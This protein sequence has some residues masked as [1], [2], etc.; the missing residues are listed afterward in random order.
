[1]SS[2]KS[3][4]SAKTLTIGISQS[5]ETKDTIDAIMEAKKHG[6]N[7]SSMCNV[8]GSTLARF[9]GNGAYL[10]AGPEYAVAS[11][12]VFSNMVATGLLFALTISN[13]SIEKQK[14]IVSELRK[15]PNTI[16]SQLIED[17]GS[18]DEAARLINTSEP[19]IFIG[20]GA[21]PLMLRRKEP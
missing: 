18:I 9:T 1:M 19:P 7:I 3:V 11:T 15:L 2:A 20:R 4:C 6:S 8:I 5:G 21:C 17:D 14:E 13:I 10:H 12:K 16:Y